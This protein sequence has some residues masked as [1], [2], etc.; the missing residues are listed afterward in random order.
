MLWGRLFF[1]ETV[2]WVQGV[3]VALVI[4]GLVIVSARGA[5]EKRTRRLRERRAT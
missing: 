1:A 3:G 2:S 5:A 4:V